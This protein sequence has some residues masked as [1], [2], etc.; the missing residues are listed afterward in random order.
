MRKSR[1]WIRQLGWSSQVFLVV[2]ARGTLA[3][4]S[5]EPH[6]R[7]TTAYERILGSVEVRQ[8]FKKLQNEKRFQEL[9][10]L[11]KDRGHSEA[12]KHLRIQVESDL[13]ALLK[14]KNYRLEVL[15]HSSNVKTLIPEDD[16]DHQFIVKS[17]GDE[18]GSK[19]EEA[20]FRVSEL[21][22][23]DL[24]PY[25]ISEK[26]G[27]DWYAFQVKM[28][29]A[30]QAK[31]VFKREKISEVYQKKTN[32]LLL[33]D[34][35]INNSD[36]HEKNWLI[37]ELGKE[38]AIDHDEH[39]FLSNGA[40]DKIAGKK[41]RLKANCDRSD[42]QSKTISREEILQSP[43]CFY[44]GEAIYSQLKKISDAEIR[45]ALRPYFRGRLQLVD[46]LIGRRNAYI[47]AYE[48]MSKKVKKP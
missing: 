37:S 36:R 47:Q 21:F 28:P 14:Q 46:E 2:A 20:A 43:H 22:G 32:A 9:F 4:G 15:P 48:A 16:P 29:N 41:N 30:R 11:E 19:N 40:F 8:K 17:F 26:R 18:L 3:H 42:L 34:Y 31:D 33:F 12:A 27:R 23:F 1:C 24:I 45:R 7:S 25:T 44:P 38:I 39:V 35:L 13:H 10:W 6:Q 5:L